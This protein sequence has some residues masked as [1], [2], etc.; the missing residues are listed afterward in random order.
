MIRR[1]KYNNGTREGRDNK[2]I[3]GMA[4]RGRREVKNTGEGMVATPRI[5]SFQIVLTP[6]SHRH[7]VAKCQVTVTTKRLLTKSK[8]DIQKIKRF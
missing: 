8:K 3:N 7:N 6:F 4:C 2:A 1:R 5:G